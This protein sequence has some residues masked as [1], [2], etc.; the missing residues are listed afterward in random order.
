MPPFRQGHKRLPAH[1]TGSRTLYHG[2]PITAAMRLI[3]NYPRLALYEQCKVISFG[4]SKPTGLM[5]VYRTGSI[6]N[7]M[8]PVMYIRK[9][10]HVY[11]CTDTPDG[12]GL[13]TCT[14][15]SS[16]FKFIDEYLLQHRG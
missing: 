9:H 3:A 11:T 5:F 6:E 2:K 4:H 12:K 7:L 14:Q 13:H 8:K 15:L 1:K 10:S 16:M